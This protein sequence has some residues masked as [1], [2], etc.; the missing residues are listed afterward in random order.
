MIY[1]KVV[2]SGDIET[3]QLLCNCVG[4]NS[5]CAVGI[6]H[7]WGYAEV[8]GKWYR[9]ATNFTPYIDDGAS[10][11]EELFNHKN[12]LHGGELK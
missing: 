6:G 3:L 4:L 11:D 2:C 5:I 12:T 9:I 10:T 7:E 1:G 8:D